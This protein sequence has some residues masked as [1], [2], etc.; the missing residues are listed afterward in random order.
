[1]YECMHL[2]GTCR[3][4]WYLAILSS[5]RS[6][7]LA[8][9]RESISLRATF[10]EARGGRKRRVSNTKNWT[11]ASHHYLTLRKRMREPLVGPSV[12]LRT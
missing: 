6:R 12:H 8:V 2:M 3:M 7:S 5:D 4:A 1:M 11:H 9:S 10:M